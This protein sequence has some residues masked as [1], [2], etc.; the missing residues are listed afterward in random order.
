MVGFLD[1]AR[2]ASAAGLVAAGTAGILGSLLDWVTITAPS[3]EQG[4]A[5]VTLP[6]NGIEATDGW[7]V[8]GLAVILILMAIMLTVRRRSFYAW[9]AFVAS[10]VMGGIAIADY[11]GIGELSSSIS[12]RMDIVGDADPAIGIT[13]VAASALIGVIA[14]LVGVAA[15]P[16]AP[17]SPD[18]V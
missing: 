4:R 8:I 18:T 10:I 16:R 11:R 17:A 13:L 12:Q 15:T 9:L 3:T 5:E 2:G 6:F 7:W 14:S 1:R